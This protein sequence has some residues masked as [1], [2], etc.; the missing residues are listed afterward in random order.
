MSDAH[1]PTKD[2][3]YDPEFGA[4]VGKRPFGPGR[5]RAFTPAK[6]KEFLKL[7]EQGNYRKDALL[8]LKINHQTFAM[9]I[10]RDPGFKAAVRAAEEKS[11]SDAIACFSKA[12]KK[13]WKAAALYLARKRPDKWAEQRNVKIDTGSGPKKTKEAVEQ[14]IAK[15]T[16]D[17][18]AMDPDT[19]DPS[20]SSSPSSPEADPT[21]V[22]AEGCVFCARPM[23]APPI[24]RLCSKQRNGWCSDD[25]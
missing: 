18:P 16:E 12:A 23:P 4:V 7:L 13:D 3:K 2:P 25:V 1:D 19:P 17:A 20:A 9:E 22:K 21:P 10:K 24:K 11:V 6:R 14:L 8:L 5:P 15:L